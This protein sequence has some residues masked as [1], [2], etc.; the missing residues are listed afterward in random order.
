MK[1]ENFKHYFK[2]SIDTKFAIEHYLSILSPINGYIPYKINYN[3]SLLLDSLNMYRFNIIKKSRQSGGTTALAAYVAI[4]SCFN[5]NETNN[6]TIYISNNQETSFYFIKLV[7]EHLL[8]LPRWVWGDE[9]Y[10]NEKNDKKSIFIR[11]TKKEIHLPNGSIIKGICNKN[12][13]ISYAA[14][15]IIVDD[16]AYYYEGDISDSFHPLMTRNDSKITLLSTPNGYDDFFFKTYDKAENFENCYHITNLY[17]FYDKSRTNNLSWSKT[18]SR[19]MDIYYEVDFD[20]E[21]M[22]KK[23]ENGWEPRSSWYNNMVNDL[24]GNVNRYEYIK[25]ELDGVFI[26]IK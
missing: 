24:G 4:K 17:W 22:K 21:K 10:G 8:E 26:S 16:A 9:Y 5:L 7:R 20:N 6:V 1:I 11:N 3:Q 18:E 13:L 2:C 19:F 15:H 12:E 14:T 23:Y 25:Q